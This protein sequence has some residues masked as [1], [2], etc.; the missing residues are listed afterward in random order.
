MNYL[1]KMDAMGVAWGV[2]LAVAVNGLYD[3]FISLL[4]WQVQ[5]A[6]IYGIVTGIVI[7]VVIVAFRNLLIPENKPAKKL[8]KLLKKNLIRQFFRR[9][10]IR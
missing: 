3:T 1:V 6:A 8:G 7:I 2:L 5:D 9:S 4:H 10:V